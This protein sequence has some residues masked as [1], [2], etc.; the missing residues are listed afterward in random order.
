MV[1]L[2]DVALCLGRAV[3]PGPADGEA[4]VVEVVEMIARD[5]IVAALPDPDA[6]GAGEDLPTVMDVAVGYC[7]V[8]RLF[9]FVAAQGC[10]ADLDAPRTQ[11]EQLRARDAV[12]PAAARQ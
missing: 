6:D 12:L 4:R 8:M 3:A 10:L 5:V 1:A 9:R 2:D 11:V 7:I